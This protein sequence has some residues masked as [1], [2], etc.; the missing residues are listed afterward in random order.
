[1]E[2]EPMVL[3]DD[4]KDELKEFYANVTGSGD[5]SV[6]YVPMT[7]SKVSTSSGTTAMSLDSALS[8]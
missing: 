6:Q 8:G 5:V 4:E 7:W 2:A 3:K 1:M